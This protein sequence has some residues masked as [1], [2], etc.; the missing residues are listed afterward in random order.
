MS[1]PWLPSVPSPQ[2][3]AA[4]GQLQPSPLAEDAGTH[5]V[6]YGGILDE[7]L[8]TSKMDNCPHL[9]NS[10]QEDFDKDGIG[11]ACDDDDD[12]DGVTDEKDNC[13]LLFNP[14]Q[15]D[16]DKDEV[17]DRCDN[18]PYVHNPAQI[19][20][21]SNGE[22][23]ACS[24]DIDGD[25]VRG[26]QPQARPVESRE[27]GAVLSLPPALQSWALCSLPS[28]TITTWLFLL[29]GRL[30]QQ[31]LGAGSSACSGS[32]PAARTLRLR[33]PSLRFLKTLRLKTLPVSAV[34]IFRFVYVEDKLPGLHEYFPNVFNE[35]DNCPYVYN[36]DQRDTDGDGVGDHCDNCPLVHN[37][38][39]RRQRVERFPDRG[40]WAQCRSRRRGRCDLGPA[41]PQDEE[42]ALRPTSCRFLPPPPI[43]AP[44]LSPSRSLPQTDM[45]N[46]LVGDQCDDDEDIDE[47]GHQN[48]QDNC[49]YIANANQADHD[50]DGRG[51]ACDPDDDNDGV[52]DDRDNCRLVFNPDQEDLD[53]GCCL[54]SRAWRKTA[55]EQPAWAEIRTR[56]D[57]LKSPAGK[58]AVALGKLSRPWG[59]AVSSSARPALHI[60]GCVPALG[61]CAAPST[62][63][64][65]AEEEKSLPL[66]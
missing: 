41:L 56:G 60:L 11:D 19:D 59:G 17:G 40:S 8:M 62:C 51:D 35:R 38:D 5:P 31:E 28:A 58:S 25:G 55:S 6:Y 63:V 48:N 26:P 45:D 66:C 12:N 42:T 64:R 27:L 33:N 46:D 49:P 4:E 32:A 34:L 15:A 18:C 39:Q 54:H 57:G 20:T 53:G 16:Y 22:G 47:D 23:D 44:L 29:S 1:Q 36:T 43:G 61:R 65:Q 21:D 52:P 10:G 14:R 50:S 30:E 7:N 37:P 9:P 2:L 3:L 13:Q 24:V